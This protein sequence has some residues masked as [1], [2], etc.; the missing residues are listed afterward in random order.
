VGEP[1]PRRPQEVNWGPLQCCA[2]RGGHPAE[3]MCGRCWRCRGS[4]P[5]EEDGAA[6]VAWVVL[7]ESI[8]KVEGFI[9]SGGADEW[10]AHHRGRGLST[11][12]PCRV[13]PNQLLSVQG[14]SINLCR[15]PYCY[16]LSFRR[17][18]GCCTSVGC[19]K[20]VNA[21]LLSRRPSGSPMQQLNDAPVD[22][23]S[24]PLVAAVTCTSVCVCK[25]AWQSGATKNRYQLMSLMYWG[26]VLRS[27]QQEDTAQT[28]R[29]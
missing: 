24:L 29:M 27:R 6:A 3:R 14:Y 4:T 17:I 9:Q 22:I 19:G 21:L 5:L 15:M 10:P 11:I 20:Q 1:L 8:H 25:S 16:L 28:Q 2:A 26:Q 7:K 18:S 13:R 23:K 12:T